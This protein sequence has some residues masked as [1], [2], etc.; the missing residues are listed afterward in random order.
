MW[1]SNEGPSVCPASV[2]CNLVLPSSAPVT[3]AP[4]K[5]GPTPSAGAGASSTLVGGAVKAEGF[6]VTAVLVAVFALFGVL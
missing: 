5:T 4:G 3:T 1:T 6:E 2:T